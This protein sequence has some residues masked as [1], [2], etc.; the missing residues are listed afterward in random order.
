MQSRQTFIC[1]KLLTAPSSA[2]TRLAV[3]PR[4]NLV[5]FSAMNYPKCVALNYPNHAAMN[6]PYCAAMNY[7]NLIQGQED[8]LLLHTP[9]LELLTPGWILY[10][11]F[12]I[13]DC[14]ARPLVHFAFVQGTIFIYTMAGEPVKD[15][16]L[17]KTKIGIISGLTLDPIKQ[18]LKCTWDHTCFLAHTF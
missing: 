1:R 17:I 8:S 18:V 16:E 15:A 4:Y 12:N 14:S 5:N 6:Y 9:G 7:P 10:F 13:C 3:D 2:V 11:F